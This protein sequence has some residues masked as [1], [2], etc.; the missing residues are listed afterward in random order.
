MWQNTEACRNR[1]GDI[2]LYELYGKLC[3]K[4]H[5]MRITNNVIISNNDINLNQYD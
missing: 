2:L 4:M 5:L 3:S 1:M